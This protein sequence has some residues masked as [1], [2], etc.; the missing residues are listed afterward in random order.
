MAWAAGA[1]PGRARSSVSAGSP[2][3]FAAD[4]TASSASASSR[5]PGRPARYSTAELLAVERAALALVERGR[6]ADAPAV[7]E[8]AR[9]TR[10][11]GRAGSRSPTSRRRW[12]ATVATSPSRVVCVVGLAGAGKT[13]ATHAVAEV[14]AQRGH[15]GARRRAVRRRRREA[16][17]RD[18]HP[19]DHAPPAA[20]RGT[21]RRRPAAGCVLVVDEAGMAETRVLAP[22]ARARR[23]GEREGDPDRRP[24]PAPRRRRGRPLRR[25]RR[26]PRR[27]RADARTAASATSSSA[28]RSHAIRAGVGRDY[29]AFAEKRERLVVS[30][31]PVATRTRLLADWWEHA[32]DDLAGNVMLALRRRD[33]AELNALA[34]ALMDSRRPARH[35]SGSRSP[36]R[37]F[38]AGD[39]I[40]CLRN[41]DALGVSNGTR[42]TVERIDPE[43]RTLTSPPTAATDRR[44]QP[45]LP[46]GRQRP[47]RLRAHR[48]RRARASRSSAP[49]CSAPARRACRSGA[50]SPSPARAQETR[51]YVTGN[52]REHESHFHDLDDRDPLTRFGRALEE[53]AVERLAVDQRPLPSGPR[54]EARP[55]IERSALTPG[56]ADAPP[57]SRAEAPC[58]LEDAIDRRTQAR[59]SRARAEALRTSSRKRRDELRAE[60]ELQRRSIDMVATSI[61]D[62]VATLEHARYDGRYSRA[63]P[64]RRSGELGRA[65]AQQNH[66]GARC[67]IPQ[68]R[69]LALAYRPTTTSTR[70]ATSELGYRLAA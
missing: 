66:S 52:P 2:R 15:P 40:V 11:S 58:A 33:V 39:R 55:E 18:R 20:R 67:S 27:G 53:S 45:P 12:C 14:F 44:A 23:A 48:P 60:V 17:G 37:E 7:T 32:R 46:R 59:G 35:A 50:T 30:E 65:S 38:A 3:G 1:R 63:R 4:R 41:S 49:S 36:G 24:A 10:S 31:S 68:A 43:Q 5:S 61:V 69:A 57:A 47:A 21:P 28:T 19:L 25:H 22:A 54:H 34:R 56:G 8:R 9:S 70:S 29:L 13:T 26:A 62:L 64:R 6:D 16:P 51:L 42:G